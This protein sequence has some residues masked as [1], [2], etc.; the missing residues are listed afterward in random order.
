MLSLDVG[1]CRQTVANEDLSTCRTNVG[2]NLDDSY[3]YV[4]KKVEKYE[5]HA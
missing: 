1:P 2:Y 3:Q 4:Y 5:Q